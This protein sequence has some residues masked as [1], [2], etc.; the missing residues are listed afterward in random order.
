MAAMIGHHAGSSAVAHAEEM[1][2]RVRVTAEVSAVL[3]EMLVDLEVWS[4]ENTRRESAAAA[5]A[6]QREV[7]ELQEK[8]GRLELERAQEAEST[9]TRAKE[10]REIREAVVS[11]LWGLSKSLKSAATN[12]KK[13]KR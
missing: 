6:R 1:A 8:I 3:Q 13:L 10:G 5:A 11:E 12:E 4:V 2:S 9:A 7:E